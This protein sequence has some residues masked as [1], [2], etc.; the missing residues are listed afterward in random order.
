VHVGPTGDASQNQQTMKENK[1][2]TLW[3]LSL[4]EFYGHFQDVFTV[5]TW[6]LESLTTSKFIWFQ[7]SLWTLKHH[8]YIFPIWFPKTS[9]IN[10]HHKLGSFCC[11]ILKSSPKMCCTPNHFLHDQVLQDVEKQAPQHSSV[12]KKFFQDE[13]SCLPKSWM[14]LLLPWILFSSLLNILKNTSKMV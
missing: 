9:L 7:S 4:V 13:S 8:A 10:M 3:M 12:R 2:L 5:C 1:A 6:F 11:S 14:L